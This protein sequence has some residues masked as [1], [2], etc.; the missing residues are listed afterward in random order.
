MK[1]LAIGNSFSEDATALLYSVAKSGGVDTKIVNL[2]IPGCPLN[3]HW[4]N[5]LEDRKDY[6]YQLNGKFTKM[7]SIKDA[8]LEENWDVVTLQQASAD[9]G[10]WS[11]YEP[12]LSQV[13]DYV[14][15]N[16]PR[17][18]LLIHQTWSYELVTENE[19][20]GNYDND[21]K[22]MYEMICSAKQNAADK[23]D[24][25]CIPCGDVIQKLR[26]LNDFDFKNGGQTLCANDGYHMHY[27]YGRYAL[28]ATWYEYVLAGNILLNDF[29]PTA[30]EDDVVDESL[31][32][33]IKDVVHDVCI[34][35]KSLA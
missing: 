6:E 32:R 34:H 28:A 12:F 26:K 24:T 10:I 22:K 17:A 18:K 21:Q 14:K 13:A 4:E 20:F 8:L 27:L 3:V 11:T 7:S 9:S 35:A 31:I 23:L 33:Q 25:T 1:V 29:V 16:V 19:A 2:Y 30:K 5:I 15:K